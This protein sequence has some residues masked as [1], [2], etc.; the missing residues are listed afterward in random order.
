MAQLGTAATGA[1]NGT[2][3]TALINATGVGAGTAGVTG[4]AVGGAGAVGGIGGA[5]EL[6]SVADLAATTPAVAPT[7]GGLLGGMSAGEGMMWSA[8]INAGTQLIGGAM[9]GRAAEKEAEEA[10]KRMTYWGVDGDGNKTDLNIGGLMGKVNLSPMAS[11]P[12]AGEYQPWQP[13]T[14]DDLTKTVG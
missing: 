13:T 12:K 14:L 6:A 7:T 9:Q 11:I 8:G 3:P 5:S 1:A 2:V 4:S 10:R